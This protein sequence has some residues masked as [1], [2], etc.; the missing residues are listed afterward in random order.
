MPKL[1]VV[2]PTLNCAHLLPAHLKSMRPWLK[3]VDEIVVVDSH[4]SDGTPEYIREHLRHPNVKVV[5][6]PRGLYQSW[7]FGISQTTGDWIYMSTVGDAI[8]PE[9]LQHLCEVGDALGCDVVASRPNFINEDD[10]PATATVWPIDHILKAA[11]RRRPLRMAGV[12]TLLFA[13]LAIPNALLGSSASNVYRGSH[14]R[15]RPFPTEFGTV[16][17]TAW[18]LRFGLQTTYGFTPE[19]GS[20]FR[21]HAKAYAKKDYEVENL[22]GKLAQAALDCFEA[23]SHP[24]EIQAGI[25]RCK[26]IETARRI[27]AAV[28]ASGK[29]AGDK[30]MVEDAVGNQSDLHHGGLAPI[31]AE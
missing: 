25:Q 28:E 3:R 6:H 17:D 26:L 21:L 4:S 14:L 1:S 11:G 7:N 16:G 13:L 5:S 15:A 31:N 9:L 19:R 18:S 12:E 27:V 23:R 22:V 29:T 8:T 10:S 30:G 2:L 24:A 20:C